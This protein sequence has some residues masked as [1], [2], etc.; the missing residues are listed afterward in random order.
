MS[1]LLELFIEG[2][3][4]HLI[5]QVKCRDRDHL[6]IIVNS[7]NLKVK[8]PLMGEDQHLIEIKHLE[9]ILIFITSMKIMIFYV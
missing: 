7:Y 1:K 3:V 5:L 2:L 6:L 4:Y 9:Q 8:D